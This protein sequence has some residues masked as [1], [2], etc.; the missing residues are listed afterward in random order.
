MNHTTITAAVADGKAILN[1]MANK[2]EYSPEQIR[3]LSIIFEEIGK[4][5]RHDAEC[6]L[7][8]REASEECR[9]Q[10]AILQQYIQDM[11]RGLGYE[12]KRS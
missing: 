6:I 8:V 4:I 11:K 3:E 2:G 1:R 9:E 12:T 10:L 7:L 5:S